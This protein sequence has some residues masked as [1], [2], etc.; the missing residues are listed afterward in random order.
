MIQ[1]IE[2]RYAGCRFRSR[3]EARWAVF[4]DTLGI[5]W[6]Y[7]PQG[8]ENRFWCDCD[9]PE[10][11]K[12]T[13]GR[14]CTGK[15]ERYLPD[16][17]LPGTKTWVEVKGE[18][19]RLL[20][21]AAFYTEMLD[22]GGQLPGVAESYGNSGGLLVLGPVPRVERRSS[23]PLHSALQH[24]KGVCRVFMEFEQSGPSYVGDDGWDH[25]SWADASC[26]GEYPEPGEYPYTGTTWHTSRRVDTVVQRAY[27]AARSA[28][29]E[30]GESGA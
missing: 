2:T 25:E 19:G 16:F 4:F 13:N 24:H 23:A 17:F 8:F 6:E 26:G 14:Q 22:W 11:W 5:T 20:E 28:R 12:F 10:N 27:T 9:K 29:F 30:H 7:E 18:E 15:H 3:L 1:A 21:K